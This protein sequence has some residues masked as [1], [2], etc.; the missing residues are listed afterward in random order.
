MLGKDNIIFK[1][2]IIGAEDEFQI[3]PHIQRAS[4]EASFTHLVYIDIFA[5]SHALFIFSLLCYS[6]TIHYVP[7]TVS[8][9][10]NRA[11]NK[12]YMPVLLEIIASRILQSASNQL[13]T[14]DLPELLN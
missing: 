1:C 2:S 12:E 3:R 11:L 14:Y 9:T 6:L 10:E 8:Y 4:F 13:I 5:Q 7:D